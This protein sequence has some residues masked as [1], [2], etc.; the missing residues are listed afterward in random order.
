MAQKIKRYQSPDS[1]RSE[2]LIGKPLASFLQ[3]AIALFFDFIAAG[4]SFGMLSILFIKFDDW[5]GLFSL[6]EDLHIEF[7]FFENWY[8]V[9]W[10]VLYFTF[11]VYLSNGLTLGKKLCRIKI[12]SLVHERINLFH[13]FERAI[14]Y[15]AST[16]EFGFGFF[17]FFI[18]PDRRTIHDR[19]AETIVIS[20][21]T[22]KKKKKSSKKRK[23]PVEK[24][25]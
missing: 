8:S 13:A 3:R 22:K 6:K 5:T 23:D 17:Q 4:L 19:I 21:A 7:S 11:S 25:S 14:G 15:G 9:I 10:L 20:T 12:V 2:A 24:A 16:L 1:S 18:R